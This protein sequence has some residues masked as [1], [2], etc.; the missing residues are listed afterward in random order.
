MKIFF[1][2][3]AALLV[4]F[5]C[6]GPEIEHG[7]R[8]VPEKRSFENKNNEKKP[9]KTVNVLCYHR[10][11]ERKKLPE[12][13]IIRGYGDIYAISP[14]KFEKHLE[15]FRDNEN[16]I[17]M[18]R[19]LDW[20]DG[21]GDIP[22][23]SL[24]ITID[25]GYRCTYTK[26]APLLE[27]YSMPAVFYLYNDFLPGGKNALTRSM[28]RGLVERGFEIGS[29]SASH[30][31]MTSH[32]QRRK[33]GGKKTLFDEK[34]YIDFL[35][36]E[37][38]GSKEY[39]EKY[40][41]VPV[42]TFSYPYGAYCGEVISFVKESGFEAAFSVVPSYN[43]KTTPR[44]AMKRHIVY[45]FTTIEDLKQKFG[46]KPLNVEIISPD[47]GWAGPEGK[48]RLQARIADDSKI[49][50]STVRFRM[51]RV[52]LQDSSYNPQTKML[53]YQYK[54]DLSRGVHRLAVTAKGKDGGD[55]EYAWQFVRKKPLDKEFLKKRLKE[56]KKT[57]GEEDAG[58]K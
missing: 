16:V 6:A 50:T 46:K 51:G 36:K 4:F 38:M 11:I 53:I 40:L 20:L 25:D 13:R 41:G 39:L 12:H 7:R 37:T 18:S 1:A 26:A 28:I 33:F 52:T 34:E 5:S 23:R 30:P 43:T 56:L 54:K 19:Y 57:R 47:D 48:L 32:R 42:R 29:H 8:E 21:K 31:V 55:Y 9:E 22:D 27:K 2:A 24:I 35:I 14:E 44:Y 3:A 45:N 15:Y 10:F 17:S 58:K 49:N